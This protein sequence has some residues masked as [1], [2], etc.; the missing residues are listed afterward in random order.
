MTLSSTTAPLASA[1]DAVLLDLDGV[2]Y[3]GDVAVP[4]AVDALASVTGRLA[5]L[6]N[7]ANRPPEVVAA[8]LTDLGLAADVDDVVTS[9]QAIASVMS[10]DLPP[11]AAV[12]TVGGEGLRQAVAARGLEPVEDH[13]DAR[14]AAVV[15][16]Y[17]P[18][19]GWRHLAAA[20]YAVG[21]GLPWYVSNTDLTIPTAEGIAPGNGA[22][23]Q[24][25][26][27]ATGVEPV[28]AGKP[29]AP[30]FEETLARLAPTRPIMV[31]DR[32][33]T[34]IRG[35][36]GAR[37]PSLFVLTGVND[38]TDVIAAPP[39]DRPDYVGADLRALHDV[40][41]AVDLESGRA[42]C[43]R[44]EAAIRDG[45]LRLTRAG[46]STESVRAL[47][48]LGWAHRDESN[49]SLQVDATIEP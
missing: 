33:D 11:G 20:A 44:A 16:G 45:R 3:R 19:V 10:R 29:F 38:L 46:S 40:H 9:A 39:S 28:V 15:Q 36:R 47:V 49:E 37:I 13:H 22:L 26:R 2:V 41:P 4:H 7:N 24:A 35:A 43:G 30:L 12:L 42:V 5:F 27:F 6:T 14:L 34:D 31:G 21:R 25:V 8:H 23:V 1:H 18:D 17:S 32:L 48:A